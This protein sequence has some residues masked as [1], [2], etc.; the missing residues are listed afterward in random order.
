AHAARRASLEQLC[1]FVPVTC[2][3]RMGSL[4]YAQGRVLSVC[5]P[6]TCATRRG[7]LRGAQYMFVFPVCSS[8]GGAARR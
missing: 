5:S 2:A 7:S 4:R 1:L 8:G 6:V 3:A